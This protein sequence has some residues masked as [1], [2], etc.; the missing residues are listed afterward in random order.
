MYHATEI[1]LKDL[2]RKQRKLYK[3]FVPVECR[4]LNREVIFNM[5]GFEH[6]HMNGRQHRRTDGDARMR[7]HLLEYA[8]TIITQSRF[9]K[10]DTKQPKETYSGKQEVYHELYFRVGAKRSPVVLTLRTVGTG[11]THFYGMRYVGKKK[12][13]T[14]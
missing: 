5:Q 13:T 11:H 12:K 1:T 2:I 3:T 9:V 6:L 8:P 14:G 4:M 10:T 7:L